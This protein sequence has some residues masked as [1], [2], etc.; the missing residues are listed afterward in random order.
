MQQFPMTLG[1]DLVVFWSLREHETVMD[2]FDPFGLV[3]HPT[4]VS[5]RPDP[6]ELRS[7]DPVIH[8]SGQQKYLT[9]D[10]AG[11]CVR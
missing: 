10:V 7:L 5:R 3:G 6:F 1:G 4:V 9:G 8:L 11:S 2:T